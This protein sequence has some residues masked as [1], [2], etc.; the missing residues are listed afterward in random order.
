[1]FKHMKMERRLHFG[2]GSLVLMAVVLGVI[3][4]T[5][6]SALNARWKLFESDT[7]AKR[8]AVL[9]GNTALS[10]TIHAFKNYLLRGGEYNKN[11][12]SGI[13]AI[14]KSVDDYRATGN[15]TQEEQALLNEI[16]VAAKLYTDSMRQLIE[17]KEKG[18]SIAELDATIKGADQPINSALQKLLVLNTNETKADSEQMTAVSDAAKRW[19]LLFGVAIVAVGCVLSVWVSRSLAC[20]VDDI[21]SVVDGLANASEE[22]SV[23]A[24][25]LSHA[26]SEQ[27]AGI[28]ETSV[29]VEQMTA[30]IAQ[31]TQ[32]AKDTDGMAAK[33]AQEAVEGG[34]AVKATASAMQQIARKISIIDD[35]AYQ[36]NLLA[37]NAAIEAARAGDQGKGFAV[38]AAE[39]RKLAERSQVAAQEIGDVATSSVELAEK[40]GKLLEEIVPGIKKTSELVQEIAVASQEQTSG[41]AQ[42]NAAVGQLNQS[43]QQNA[44]SSEE[45]AVTAEEMRSQAEQ[46]WRLMAL[47][48][49]Q[50]NEQDAARALKIK[51][52]AAHASAGVGKQAIKMVPGAGSAQQTTPSAVNFTKF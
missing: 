22:V 40:A 35:I 51:P 30:S 50:K 44:S 19:V 15:L 12:A 31:N 3:A 34:E 46:L 52:V 6:L 5:N 48:K 10:N 7:L 45:L 47:F 42:I 43:A 32:N 41:V 1:M 16:R 36:T 26:A 29:S 24:Q 20:I 2:F 33:A 9:A 13:D 38:V 14:E 4:F 23:T 21:R 49:A 17:L 28:E 25:S 37:L 8:D 18:M 27:A 11:F 39:V